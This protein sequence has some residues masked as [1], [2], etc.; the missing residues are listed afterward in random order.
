M[1]P[2]N[3]GD[4]RPPLTDP[5]LISRKGELNPR[6]YEPLCTLSPILTIVPFRN[7][8]QIKISRPLLLATEADPTQ[9][10]KRFA[11]D[12]DRPP[13]VQTN[14]HWTSLRTA[15]NTRTAFTLIQRRLSVRQ[16][17]RHVRRVALRTHTGPAIVAGRPLTQELREP[18]FMLDLFMQDRQ[19]QVVGAVVFA[20]GVV[21]N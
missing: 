5:Q 15:P 14:T 17:F 6:G 12:H 10:A 8:V 19:G 2:P 3:R 11:H 1:E 20:G 7:F 13:N 9:L 4:G 16:E 21:T 18:G